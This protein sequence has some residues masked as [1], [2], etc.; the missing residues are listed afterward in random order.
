MSWLPSDGRRKSLKTALLWLSFKWKQNLVK[1]NVPVSSLC[2]YWASG[3]CV[4]LTHG[5]PVFQKVPLSLL[6]TFS[7]AWIMC[8]GAGTDRP[9]C[10][11]RLF[12]SPNPFKCSSLGSQQRMEWDGESEW[13][14]E[15][16][17]KTE[18]KA[19]RETSARDSSA[20][21]IN[22]QESRCMLL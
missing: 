3:V 12:I 16:E 1:A 17:V 21:K 10:A 8:A 14:S 9:S 4:S 13:V 2:I 22:S 5:Q 6:P 19:Q 20:Y 15:W 11:V 7:K 18:E